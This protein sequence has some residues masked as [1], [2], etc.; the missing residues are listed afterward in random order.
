[1]TLYYEEDQIYAVD[2]NDRV[3]ISVDGMVAEGVITKIHP[4]KSE[5]TVRYENHHDAYRTS[6]NPRKRSVRLP[7][8][9]V[10]LIARDG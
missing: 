5:V 3:E 8:A 1:M 2:L 6:G 4:H 9:D 7:V 10:T